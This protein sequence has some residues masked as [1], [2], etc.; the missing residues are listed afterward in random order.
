[1]KVLFDT[2]ALISLVSDDAVY[3]EVAQ[4]CFK[5]LVKKKHRV[6]ISA[7]TLAEY[8]VRGNPSDVYKLPFRIP[9]F[10]VPHAEKAAEFRKVTGNKSKVARANPHDRQFISVDTMILAQ[11]AIEHVDYV[12][13]LDHNTFARAAQALVDA[14]YRLPQI[15]LLDDA[16]LSHLR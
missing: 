14:G 8:S 10:G 5:E 1:M 12:L 3:H 13:T 11:A 7:L 16:P 15:V 9:S 4:Q 6:Y 2:C